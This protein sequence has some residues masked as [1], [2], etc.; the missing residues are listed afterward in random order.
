MPN[1]DPP[2]EPGAKAVTSDA[3]PWQTLQAIRQ[4]T[5]LVHN[6]TNFVAMDLA[7]NV[8]L[9]V[10]ASPAMVQAIEEVEEF[11]A[12]ADALTVNIGTLSADRAE[13]MQAA[14]TAAVNNGK[15]WVLD[16]VGVGGTRFRRELAG[17]LCALRPTVIR[18]NGS[19]IMTL[20]DDAVARASGVDSA[21]ASKEAVDAARALAAST[22][23]VVAVTGAIDYVTDGR[24]VIA[25]GGG[26]PMMTKVTALGCALTCL[27]GACCAV[28]AA[29]LAATVDGLAIM[30]VAGQ[31]AATEA[32]GPGSLRVRL[33]DVL[34]NLDERQLGDLS[35]I[36]SETPLA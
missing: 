2:G 7:A 17:R 14:A 13:A 12:K 15:P 27:I 10:G 1:C 34:Y 8:M 21:H 16:P 11:V 19:E 33:I 29:P 32:A 9:A 5:P 22:G 31:L 6:I 30:G 26:D 36:S 20:S 18:G 28:N 3:S 23:A 24:D 4:R 25:V 35:N